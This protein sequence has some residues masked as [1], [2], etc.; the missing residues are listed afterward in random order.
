MSKEKMFG[1]TIYRNC[2]NGVK[3][4]MPKTQLEVDS[5]LLQIPCQKHNLKLSFVQYIYLIS[6]RNAKKGQILEKGFLPYSKIIS[7][8]F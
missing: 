7:H 4:A 5:S 2:V 1:N 3:V 8:E 6:Y